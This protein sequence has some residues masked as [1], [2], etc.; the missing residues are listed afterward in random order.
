[1]ISL[2]FMATLLREFLNR[3]T[4]IAILL[5]MA[6]LLMGSCI[7][8]QAAELESWLRAPN[9]GQLRDFVSL[10]SLPKSDIYEVAPTKIDGAVLVYLAKGPFAI[11]SCS[12]ADFLAGGHY[13]CSD[14]KK[15]ILVRAVFS[16]GGTGSFAIR[17]DGKTL[18]VDHAS[19]GNLGA[20]R[21][22]PLIV[23]LPSAPT[24]VY[25]WAGSIK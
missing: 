11:I 19:L 17:Y 22:V 23:N 6:P 7:I 5:T 9:E 2:A 13:N 16:N 24:E 25:S 18:Y 10:P 15:P 4:G 21:N 3:R 8:G 1:M 14:G 20:I 12:A